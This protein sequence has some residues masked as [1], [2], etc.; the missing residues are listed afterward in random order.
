[1]RS[2][3]WLGL[4]LLA[5]LPAARLPGQPPGTVAPERPSHR[6]L[7]SALERELRP[8]EALENRLSRSRTLK[9]I[10][11]KLDDK[12]A[13]ADI[14]ELARKLMKDEQFMESLRTQFTN[15]EDLERILGKVGKGDGIGDDPELHRVIRQGLRN[16]NLNA[17]D[18]EKMR[19]WS[20]MLREKGVFERRE[21]PR[22]LGTKGRD[23]GMGKMR[24]TG[25][26]PPPSIPPPPLPAPMR[27]PPLPKREETT[28]EWLKK[29]IEQMA[30]DLDRWKDSPAAKSWMNAFQGV[31]SRMP[32][33][34]LDTPALTQRANRLSGYLPR[35]NNVLPKIKPPRLPEPWLPR[36][37]NLAVPRMRGPDSPLAAPGRGLVWIVVLGVLGVVLWRAGSWFERVRAA[38]ASAWKLGPW[39]VR[40]EDV[41]T[42]GELVR[43][44]EYLALLRLGREAR[45]H[46]HL[47]LARQLGQQ[48][49]LD[50]NRCRDAAQDLAQLYEQ[51]RYTPDDERLA[52]ED[53]HRARRE[54]CY[55]AGVTAA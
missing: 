41:A 51:A 22:P 23:D 38:R 5:L 47:D 3:H 37:P 4:L 36:L 15:P 27:V 43:A 16:Q 34:P 2:R 52:E 30:A 25:V 19:D 18:K 20:D 12:S 10:R 53:L 55:L 13:H 11:D 6:P 33:N 54:L 29:R 21:P 35:L 39:P 32:K 28:P 8:E 42:R 40:P 44:F 48:P 50:Q 14:H 31:S 17:E 9:Q 46:H 45:T 1:M 7:T 49:T 26:G 24:P